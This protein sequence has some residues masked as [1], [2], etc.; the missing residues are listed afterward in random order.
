YAL[1]H[2]PKRSGRSRHCAPVFMTQS[3]ASSMRRAGRPGRPLAEAGSKRWAMRAHWASVRA[4]RLGGIGA[5]SDRAEAT[6]HFPDTAWP[7]FVT[8]LVQSARDSGLVYVSAAATVPTCG[9]PHR[10]L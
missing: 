6:P 1:C 2:G 10:G 5:V 7:P 4:C 9:P 3:A 8:A